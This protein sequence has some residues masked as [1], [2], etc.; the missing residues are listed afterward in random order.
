MIRRSILTKD[1][2]RRRGWKKDDRKCLFCDE[3]E[4]IDH[5]FF[6]C[7]LA[8]YCWN[9]ACCAFNFVGKPVSVRHLFGGWMRR[10]SGKHR[11]LVR[12]GVA[13]VLWSIWKTRN[14]ACFRSVL[15]NNPCSITNMI[16]HWMTTWAILQVKETNQHAINWGAKLF[17]RLSSEVF[18]ANH[19]WRPAT[20]RIEN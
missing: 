1:V 2:L 14:N 16:G 6:Q 18:Q 15:P 9:V 17:V 20:K 7:P 10:F 19:G 4:T 13:A 12:V 3:E 8:R 11:R 5:L